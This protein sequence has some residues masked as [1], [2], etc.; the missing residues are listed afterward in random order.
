MGGWQFRGL[1]DVP[2]LAVEGHTQRTGTRHGKMSYF[3]NFHLFPLQ[4]IFG[5][6]RGKVDHTRSCLRV[7]DEFRY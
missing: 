7:L 6:L 3:V 1:I 5:V 2:F 4:N